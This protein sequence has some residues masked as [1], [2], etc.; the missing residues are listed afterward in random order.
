MKVIR[1]LALVIGLLAVSACGGSSSATAGPTSV[2]ASEKEYS[3]TLA[4]SSAKA[5]EVTFDIKNAGTIQHEFVVVS[6][7]LPADQLPQVA[8]KVNEDALTKVDEVEDINPGDTPTLKVNLPAGHYVVFCNIAGH[9]ASGM[10]AAFT[11]E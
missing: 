11:A 10:H 4:S 9:Y 8:D 6:T 7:D 1:R 3:I 5:G 2:G